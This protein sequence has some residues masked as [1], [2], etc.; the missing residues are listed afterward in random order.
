VE[1]TMAKA[2]V[3]NTDCKFMDPPYYDKLR[4]ALSG[5]SIQ[6]NFSEILPN[7]SDIS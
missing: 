4:Y 5:T 6:P 7:F 2:V 3:S 1:T